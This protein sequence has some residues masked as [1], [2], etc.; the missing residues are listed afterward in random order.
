MDEKYWKDYT[1]FIK[2]SEETT[3]KSPADLL[4]H[5]KTL[6]EELEH[7]NYQLEWQYEESENQKTF[8]NIHQLL[9]IE[10]LKSNL[11]KQYFENEITMLD[12]RIKPF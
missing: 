2:L 4:E 5:Y 6:V 12:E 9:H 1:Q 7:D 10:E 8:Q 3:G 11:L